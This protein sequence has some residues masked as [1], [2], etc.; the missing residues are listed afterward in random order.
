MPFQA[1]FPIRLTQGSGQPQVQPSPAQA[2]P[3]PSMPESPKKSTSGEP[4]FVAPQVRHGHTQQITMGGSSPVGRRDSYSQ[5]AR[6]QEQQEAKIA[7]SPA[8]MT[9]R[10]S[11]S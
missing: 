5:L 1:P 4:H 8:S 3:Q 10:L 7:I 9:S 6:L 11:R 2:A